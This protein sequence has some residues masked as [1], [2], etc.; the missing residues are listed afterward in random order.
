[1][2]QIVRFFLDYE[3]HR[4]RVI[5]KGLTEQQAREHCSNP[6]TS[7]STAK[8]SRSRRITRLYGDWFDGY[9]ET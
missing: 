6:E 3:R 8:T 7:S 2:Y 1:M 4:R 9:E 5:K